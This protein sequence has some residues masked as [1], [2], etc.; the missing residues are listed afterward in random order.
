MNFKNVLFIF[1]KPRLHSRTRR[2]SGSQWCDWRRGNLKVVG[3]QYP[4]MNINVEL[5]CLIFQPCDICLHVTI[6]NKNH[7]PV[8]VE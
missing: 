4:G 8:V 1:V 7:L 2:K 6:T 5:L 3:H